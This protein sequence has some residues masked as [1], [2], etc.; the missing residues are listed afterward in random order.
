MQQPTNSSIETLDDLLIALDQCYPHVKGSII[1]LISNKFDSSANGRFEKIFDDILLAFKFIYFGSSSFQF[2]GDWIVDEEGQVSKEEQI[3][4]VCREMMMNRMRKL[5]LVVPSELEHVKTDFLD[6]LFLD[7]LN[8]EEMHTFFDVLEMSGEKTL[9]LFEFRSIIKK[10]PRR[11]VEKTLDHLSPKCQPKPV[12]FLSL[13]SPFDDVIEAV[14]CRVLYCDSTMETFLRMRV[15][16]ALRDLQ[17]HDKR[18]LLFSNQIYDVKANP[19]SIIE[20]I[21]E[22][23]KKMD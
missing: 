8:Y 11:I 1:Q 15:V 7:F 22:Q 12:F 13:Q 3:A 18:Q 17:W 19:I 4:V 5:F 2:Y 23:I 6:N 9:G 16:P 21:E 20:I 14:V 10:F